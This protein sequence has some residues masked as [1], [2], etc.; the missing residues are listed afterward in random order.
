MRAL[1]TGLIA[2]AMWTLCTPAI[3]Q[4]QPYRTNDFGGFRDVLPPGTNGRSNLVE[5]TLFLTTGKR[6]PHNDDQRGMYARLLSATPGVTNDN[7]GALFKDS[8]FGVAPGGQ[9]RAYSPIEGLTITRDTAF[10]VPHVYGASRAAAMFGLGYVAAEDRLFFMDLLRHA[11]RGQLSSYAG[12]AEGNRHMDQEQWAVAPYTEEDLLAQVDQLDDLYGDAGR[13]LQEDAAGYVAGINRYIDEAR[14]DVT[15]MPA[16][17]AALG[18]LLGPAPWKVTDVIATASLVGGIFGRGGGQELTQMELRRSFLGRYGLRRGDAL[19]REWA[20]FEDADAPTTLRGRRFPYQTPPKK[21]A[22]GGL[23]IADAGSLHK[24]SV[25]VSGGATAT[26][27]GALA[28]IFSRALRTQGM[29][30]AL[31]INAQ[32]SAGGKPLAV[33]G[34]QTGYFSPQI[35]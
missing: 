13:Q 26:R 7:L 6:P 33:F 15:K 23:A 19:W 34:P 28:G 8:S 21:P 17:Y 9:A 10:G 24:T 18:R 27:G 2:T 5:L 31:L 12:G 3:A 20:A 29:S 4:V 25:V 16:E 1:I 32:E 11:G 22:P 30:N 35:L 14:L